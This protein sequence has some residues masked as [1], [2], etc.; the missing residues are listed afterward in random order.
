MNFKRNHGDA[1]IDCALFW[2]IIFLPP[3]HA[4]ACFVGNLIYVKPDIGMLDR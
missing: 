3:E 1:F 4:L 2:Y